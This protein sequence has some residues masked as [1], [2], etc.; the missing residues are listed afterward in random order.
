MINT[1]IFDLDGTLANTK[2]DL[3][4]CVNYAL[5][6]EGFP[7]RS[8]LEVVNRVG[9]GL[10]MLLKRCLPENFSLD[11]VKSKELMESFKA[12]YLENCCEK[13]HLYP[14]IQGM[15]EAF[16][17]LNLAVLT[18]KSEAYSLKILKKLKID[19][20]FSLVLCGDTVFQ[21]KPHPSGI[22]KIFSH[23][24]VKAENC[25]MI[26]DSAPDV[27]AAK[28][29]GCKS[30]AIATGFSRGLTLRKENPDYILPH[31]RDGLWLIKK[32]AVPA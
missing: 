18:N 8:Q 2:E 12:C 21:K 19:S 20:Y 15:L 13:T 26:G 22:Q 24:K 11:S 27:Q 3:T 16:K 5:K 30:L 23:F 32:L 31:A 29:A 25:L 7:V 1:L 9:L 17:H 28:N 6:R 14:G 4:Y 10:E